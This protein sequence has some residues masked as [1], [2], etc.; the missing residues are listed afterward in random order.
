MEKQQ[1]AHNSA[2][3]TIKQSSSAHGARSTLPIK[4]TT[5][6]NDI[7]LAQPPRNVHNL[8]SFSMYAALLR[9]LDFYG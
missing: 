3:H 9:Q 5:E 6:H 4:R 7:P 1:S 2:S 8:T